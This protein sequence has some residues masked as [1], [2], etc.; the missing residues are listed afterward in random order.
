MVGLKG[1]L[2]SCSP[3]YFTDEESSPEGF[4]IVEMPGREPE[5]PDSTFPLTFIYKIKAHYRK[6]GTGQ[7]IT[8]NP[9]IILYP[10]SAFC[11]FCHMLIG[12]PLN[13]L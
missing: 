5:S 1:Y 9:I 10:L 11:S 13:M 4:Q 2:N 7:E 3:N 12:A 8:S 6:T